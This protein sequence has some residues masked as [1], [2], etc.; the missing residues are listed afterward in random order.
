MI[1][2]PDSDTKRLALT[3]STVLKFISASDPVLLTLSEIE[4]F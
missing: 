1:V 2:F 4:Q 3:N